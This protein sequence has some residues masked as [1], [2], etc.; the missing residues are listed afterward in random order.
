M[1]NR[2]V[3]DNDQEMKEPSKNGIL[4]SGKEH[5]KE[6][7]GF[8]RHPST[9][10]YAQ[11]QLHVYHR[12]QGRYSLWKAVLSMICIDN[13][14][15]ANR[16]VLAFFN[17]ARASVVRW[18][19]IHVLSFMPP[20]EISPIELLLTD[21]WMATTTDPGIAASLSLLALAGSFLEL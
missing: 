17:C 1:Q 20:S 15:L 18:N 6:P 21:S 19:K 12:H 14:I 9:S 13:R 4:P 3:K 7:Q 8:Q 5:P 2:P 11:P 16:C 10:Q